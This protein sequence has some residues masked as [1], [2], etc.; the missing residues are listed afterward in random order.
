MTRGI[1]IFYKDT[2][3]TQIKNNQTFHI[4]I[5]YLFNLDDVALPTFKQVDCP[6]DQ[7]SFTFCVNVEYNDARGSVD[8]ILAKELEDTPT[9]LKGHLDSNG[10]KVVI[11]LKDDFN[12]EDTVTTQLLYYKRS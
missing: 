2:S 9:V 4:D 11:V 3:K 6:I 8:L 10:R 1:L 12:D 5:K 7:S